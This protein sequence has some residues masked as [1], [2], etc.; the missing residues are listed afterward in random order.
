MR[1]WAVWAGSEAHYFKL[2]DSDL[3]CADGL[4]KLRVRKSFVCDDSEFDISMVD[5]LD[6]FDLILTL[7]VFL[8]A[9]CSICDVL[10]V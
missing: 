5:F 2:S 9:L 6:R 4:L 3:V 7:T 10:A 8:L 1:P